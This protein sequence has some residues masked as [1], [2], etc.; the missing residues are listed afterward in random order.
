MQYPEFEN[1]VNIIADNTCRLIN[2]FSKS[3]VSKMPYKNQYLL[4]EVIKKL[5]ERV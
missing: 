2:E 1:A 3:I 4:E 5:Q